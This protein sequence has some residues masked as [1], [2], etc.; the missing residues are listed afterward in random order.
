MTIPLSFL[1]L[2]SGALSFVSSLLNAR[3]ETY[4]QGSEDGA[5][6]GTVLLLISKI[7]FIFFAL[8]LPKTNDSSRYIAFLCLSAIFVYL[9]FFTWV[10]ARLETYFGIFLILLLPN[11][12][13]AWKH[14]GI[15]KLIIACAML[16]YFALYVSNYN[17]LVPYVF[18]PEWE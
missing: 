5:G 3:Y 16:V 12:L 15:S 9:G 6:F 2:N 7:F 10:I 1:V 8:S 18:L 11:Q 13:D 4:L 14:G 17:G